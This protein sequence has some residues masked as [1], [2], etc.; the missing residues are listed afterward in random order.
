VQDALSS[1]L[2]SSGGLGLAENLYRALKERA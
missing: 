1:G 2:I